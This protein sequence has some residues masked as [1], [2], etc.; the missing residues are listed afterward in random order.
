MKKNDLRPKNGF[1]T[2]IPYVLLSVI[3]AIAI[4][5]TMNI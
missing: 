1:I 4:V 2:I 3:L 5:V